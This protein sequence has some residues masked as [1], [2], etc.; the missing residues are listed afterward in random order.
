MTIWEVIV[1]PF[2]GDRLREAREK[3][4][5][6]LLQLGEM[7]GTSKSIIS[8]YERGIRFPKHEMLENLARAVSVDVD[9]L[10]GKT[11]VPFAMKA[12]EDIF[13]GLSPK[14]KALF[15][16]L[17]ELPPD[18]YEKKMEEIILFLDNYNE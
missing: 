9:Y 4:N 15:M 6:S 17:R 12:E 18:E 13:A 5:I 10:M 11:D 3:K 16:A 1:M 14:E 7:C 2:M 8:R